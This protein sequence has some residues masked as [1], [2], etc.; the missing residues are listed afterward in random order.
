M[1]NKIIQLLNACYQS[2]NLYCLL[3]T[4]EVFIILL[5]LISFIYFIQFDL[6][7]PEKNTQN[8]LKP[9]SDS[10]YASFSTKAGEM[11][12]DEMGLYASLVSNP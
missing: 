12:V 3:D 10:V 6:S 11:K 4:D 9:E 8:L 1:S 5:L 7:P 2:K